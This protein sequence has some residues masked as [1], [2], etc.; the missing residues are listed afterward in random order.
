[1]LS[2]LQLDLRRAIERNEFLL[3]YQPQ[4]R[5]SGSIVAFEALLRWV[6]PSYGN[7]APDAFIPIAEESGLIFPISRWVLATACSEAISWRR[8]LGV[9]VNISPVQFQDAGLVPLV[10]NILD[11]TG[12]DPRRLE[13]EITEGVLIA[14]LSRAVSVLNELRAVGVG[15]SLDD[16]GTGYASLRYVDALPI[17]TIK[18]D[19]YFTSKIGEG[20]RADTIIRTVIGLGHELEMKVLAEGVE[21]AEQSAFLAQQKCDLQQGYLYGAPAHIKAYSCVTHGPLTSA[22]PVAQ[23]C[24]GANATTPPSIPRPPRSS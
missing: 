18:I 10:R 9:A 20:S 1:M 24:S 19:K 23:P 14:D 21:T 6:H 4:V 12:L 8:P 5:P 22:T 11:A 17:S 16:F 13:L 7:V 15:I 3:H 2:T